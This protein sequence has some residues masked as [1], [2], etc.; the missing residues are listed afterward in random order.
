MNTSQNSHA[1]IALFAYERLDH[2]TKTLEALRANDGA[3]LTE[4]FVF[5][6]GPRDH[7]AEKVE[8][9]RHYLRTLDG[10]KSI[11]LVERE[12]NIGLAENIKEGIRFVFLQHDRIIVLED[13]IVTSPSFLRYMNAALQFYHQNQTVGHINSWNY[14]IL[15]KSQDEFSFLDIMNCWGWATWKDRWSL[16]NDDEDYWMRA[17]SWKEK[18][19][20]DLIFIDVAETHHNMN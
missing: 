3:K 10:F 15:E 6:D 11:N 18:Y 14:P 5:S 12:R 20:I 7:N 4:L 9:V 16:F 2:L 13:D 17:L 8:N 1:P 19:K